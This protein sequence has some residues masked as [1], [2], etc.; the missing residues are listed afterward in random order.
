MPQGAARLMIPGR[1]LMKRVV[2]GNIQE[3]NNDVATALLNPL[4]GHH[5][6]FEDICNVIGEFLTV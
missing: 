4:P 5:I 1:P 3:R 2:T 6:N